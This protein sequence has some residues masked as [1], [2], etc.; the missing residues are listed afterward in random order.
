[1]LPI[2]VALTEKYSD[3]EIAVLCG[4]GRSFHGADV[5]NGV[6]PDLEGVVSLDAGGAGKDRQEQS[7]TTKARPLQPDPLLKPRDLTREERAALVAFLQ[8]LYRSRG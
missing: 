8:A 1:M 2:H 5:H 3:R 6:F 4:V 7:R